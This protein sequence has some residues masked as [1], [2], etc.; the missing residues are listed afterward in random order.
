MDVKEILKK[1][2]QAEVPKVKKAAV[3]YSGGLD[4]TLGIEMLRR[5]YKAEAIV[6]ICIDVGQG[7][8]EIIEARRKA[9]LLD[10]EK[11][12]I[13]VDAKPEFVGEWLTKAI[14]ANS[15]YNG[16]P[17]STSMT[18]Q[19]VARIVAVEGAKRG[20]DAV[21]EGSTGKGNDQYRMHN[22]FKLFAPHMEVLAFVRDFDLTRKEEEA[23]CVEWGVPV[24]EQLTGGDDKTMWCRSIASGAIDL[25]QELPDDIWQ[26]LTP[27]RKAPENG[28]TV[29]LRYVEGLPVELNGKATPLDELIAGLNVIAGRNGVGYIDMFEDG[30][31]DLKSREIYEA[32]AAHVILK[33]H[34]DLEQ[35]CLPKEEIQFKKTVDAKWAYMTYHGEWYHPLKGDLDAFIAQSQ[36]V[37]NG[38]FRVDLYKGNIVIT[39]RESKTSLFT[40]E[41]RSIKSRG[42]DQ[43]WAVNAAKI[44]GLPFEI[45]SKRNQAMKG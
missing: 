5:K 34:R 44:R 31:M 1:V 41:I 29:T 26:W 36:K 14:R 18:R 15:D 4:S 7:E 13:L 22:T 33:L 9:K 16:Y 11:D 27:P 28:E 23:I 3:A 40:P 10:F 2:E 6:P 45:L 38:S 17:V 8:D 19:L 35:Q 20:C 42:Y 39:S 37:V 32:P 25:N 21:M 24:K 30:I 12:L 43:R